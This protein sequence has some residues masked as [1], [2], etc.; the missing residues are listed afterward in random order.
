MIFLLLKYGFL[1]LQ[2]LY[3]A[4]KDL[5][6]KL[7]IEESKIELSMGMSADYIE[8]IENGSTMVRVG[9]SIFGDRDYSQK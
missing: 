4:R 9:S 7:G 2:N 8:A 6:A 5:A 1:L 3:Q